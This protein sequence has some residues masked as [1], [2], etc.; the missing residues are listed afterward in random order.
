MPGLD[1]DDFVGTD[2]FLIQERLGAGG[3]G[4]VYRAVDRQRNHLVALKT[5]RNVAATALVHFKQEFRALADVSHPNLVTLYELSSHDHQWFF[6]MELVDGVNFLWYVRGETY[7]AESGSTSAVSAAIPAEPA[8]DDGAVEAAPQGALNLPRLR[9]ALPQLAEGVLALH[10]AGKLHR[11]IKPSNVLVTREGRV[12]LLDFGLVA[13]LDPPQTH[14]RDQGGT[15]AYMSPEQ[16]AGLPLT[17]ASDWY[18]VGAMLYQAL[19]GRLP[20]SGPAPEVMRRKQQGEP[21]PPHEL[22]PGVPRDLDELCRDLLRRDP[23]SRPAGREVLRALMGSSA[24]ILAPSFPPG[25]A[26][27]VGREQHLE[28]LRDAFQTSKAGRAVIVAVHGGSGMGK[29]ALVRRFLVELKDLH[30]EAVVLIGRCY[31][32][33]SV[34]YKALDALVDALSR[35]LRRL[36]SAQAEA[37]LPHDILALA[38]VFPVLRQVGAVNRAR[39]AVL[40][41]PDSLELQRRAFR[42]LRELFVRVADRQPLVLFIDDLQWG[43]VDSG[44]LLEHLMSPPDPPALLLIGCYRSEE[45]NTAPLLKSVL[46]KRPP[47]VSLEMRDIVVGELSASEAQELARAL[48]GGEPEARNGRAEAIA[49][50]SRGNPYFIEELVRFSQRS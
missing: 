36:P 34:P 44:T 50:E 3:Y 12:V 19:T 22:A 29:S 21:A 43:D 32:R 27:F 18:N 24:A 20:F 37:Y 39:R 33:E 40:D 5:L 6:T 14:T 13:E 31:E 23:A 2:R 10:D 4:V 28:A 11:D 41:I 30:G 38:K 17:E 49:R 9:R 1:P 46:S 45:A 26:L 16:V 35:Y 7:P 48:I 25:P 15:P 42:A 47:D 8:P